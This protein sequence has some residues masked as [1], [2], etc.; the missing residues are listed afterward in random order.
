MKIRC[1]NR[2]VY[3]WL[4]TFVRLECREEEY[5]F[6]FCVLHFPQSL[7]K[8]AKWYLTLGTKTAKGPDFTMADWLKMVLQPMIGEYMVWLWADLMI[9]IRIGE[10]LL[11][12]GSNDW[13]KIL[14]EFSNLECNTWMLFMKL[15]SACAGSSGLF[16]TSFQNHAPTTFFELDVWESL[17]KSINI[18]SGLFHEKQYQGQAQS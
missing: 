15:A 16:S 18:F 11:I 9:L 12:T 8:R 5:F 4:A 10:S 7:L 2:D 6:N 3:L 1:L 17:R 13:F 14:C